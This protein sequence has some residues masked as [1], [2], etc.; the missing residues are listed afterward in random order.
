MVPQSNQ[1]MYFAI[2][3]R[4]YI[5]T[6]FAATVMEKQEINRR[7]AS[8]DAPPLAQVFLKIISARIEV[9]EEERKFS[10]QIQGQ[11]EFKMILNFNYFCRIGPVGSSQA[12]HEFQNQVLVRDINAT[13]KRL[14]RSH[15]FRVKFT[16]A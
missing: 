4:S 1:E 3:V 5:N 8:A 12:Q 14:I 9:K 2:K 15:K 10:E 6:H 7:R 16:F 13:S 11:F